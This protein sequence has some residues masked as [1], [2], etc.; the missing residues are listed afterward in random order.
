MDIFDVLKEEACTTALAAR[1]KK[2]CLVE[3]AR[4]VHVAE[5]DLDPEL[6]LHAFQ[7]RENQGS[8]GFENGIAIP[9]ARLEGL[10][11][12][13]LGIA[14]SKKGIP[15]DSI[16]N[17]K[18]HLFFSLV[19]PADKSREFLQLLAQISLVTKNPAIRH[20]L[21]KAKSA[22]VLK[23]IFLENI[24]GGIASPPAGKRQLFTLVLYDM[25]FLDDVAQLFL[26][27]GVRGASV[28]SSSGMRGVLSRV[29]LFAD[30]LDFLGE[31]GHESK[32]ITAIVAENQV[33]P[34]VEGI[35]EIMGGLDAHSGAAVYVIDLVF[36]KGS[37][38]TF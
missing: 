35:E 12:F 11:S 21:L 7:E 6:V 8:T 10:D 9:H 3:L 16:D 32:T 26:E 38:E 24:P 5:S 20:Q 18:S 29:P 22:L 14:V 17:K 4:L 36:S 15:F 19:G 27:L 25:Q 31:H 34:L 23:E 1:N 13:I 37:F 30:F 28:T 2:E 33:K